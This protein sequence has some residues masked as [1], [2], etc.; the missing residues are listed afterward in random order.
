CSGGGAGCF[1]GRRADPVGGDRDLRLVE[2]AGEPVVIADG[3][4]PDRFGRN[5]GQRLGRGGREFCRA[6]N[7]GFRLRGGHRSRS[8]FRRS[9]E[10]RRGFGQVGGGRSYGLSAFLFASGAGRAGR[11][12]WLWLARLLQ[13]DEPELAEESRAAGKAEGQRRADGTWHG[14]DAWAGI[15]F[16]R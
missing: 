13:G 4:G 5:G 6:R 15:A 10:R 14:A 16:D 3:Q 7:R 2:T 8:D 1:G 12:R 11:A 9:H